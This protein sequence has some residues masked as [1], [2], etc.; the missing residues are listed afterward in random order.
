MKKA[1]RRGDKKGC[2]DRMIKEDEKLD[3]KTKKKKTTEGCQL[4][5]VL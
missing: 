1:E 3:E 2:K 4:A 5:G